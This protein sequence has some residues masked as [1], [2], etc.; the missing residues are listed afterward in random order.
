MDISNRKSAH[1]Y[2][3]KS[4]D[5]YNLPKYSNNKTV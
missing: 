1:N 3:A 2:Y 5:E 4:K